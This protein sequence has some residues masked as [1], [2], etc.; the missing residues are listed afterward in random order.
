MDVWRIIIELE[1]FGVLIE[2]LFSSDQI[3]MKI[4]KIDEEKFYNNFSIIFHFIQDFIKLVVN[5]MF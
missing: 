2:S 4:Y 1:I 5:T 3:A